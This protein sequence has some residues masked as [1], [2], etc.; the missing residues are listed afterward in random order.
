M[1]IRPVWPSCS[2][3]TDGQT[4]MWKLIVVFRNFAN[5]R[6]MLFYYRPRYRIW[7][8]LSFF[9]FSFTVSLRF[10]WYN[11][12]H[13]L[14]FLHHGQD[15]SMECQTDPSKSVCLWFLLFPSKQFPKLISRH[16]PV[17]TALCMNSL[18]LFLL[19]KNFCVILPVQPFLRNENYMA[20]I[21]LRIHN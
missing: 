19:L 10:F 5:A 3:R 1:K 4:N 13:F 18:S 12:N 7:L 21:R 14:L 6:K 17:L 9:Y 8:I 15:S 20:Y 11:S 16:K 2:M